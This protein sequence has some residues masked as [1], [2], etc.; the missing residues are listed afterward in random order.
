MKVILIA[1][2]IS[3]LAVS[4]AVKKRITHCT[5]YG[6][7]KEM[8]VDL[9]KRFERC[10]ALEKVRRPRG[11]DRDSPTRQRLVGSSD[12]RDDDS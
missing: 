7:R 5:L 2:M 12:N 4:P 8:R 11:D 3:S 10:K 1:K 9:S 6:V